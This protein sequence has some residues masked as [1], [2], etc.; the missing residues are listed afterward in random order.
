MPGSKAGAYARFG[1]YCSGLQD[2]DAAHFM[3]PAPEALA[4][5]PHT[6]HLMHLAQVTL[7]CQRQ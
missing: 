6:R 3:L 1:A 2:F 4:M 7:S 5:D